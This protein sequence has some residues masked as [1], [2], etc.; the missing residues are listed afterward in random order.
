MD[1]DFISLDSIQ[2]HTLKCKTKRLIT[3]H[4]R[5]KGEFLNET[6]INIARVVS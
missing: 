2:A 4:V 5:K 6:T 1:V 3:T